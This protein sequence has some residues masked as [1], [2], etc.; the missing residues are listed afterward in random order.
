MKIDIESR[1]HNLHLRFPTRLLCSKMIVRIADRLGRKYAAE[2]MKSIPPEALEKLCAE[3]RRT[4]DR[5]GKWDLVDVEAADGE[6]VK[7]VL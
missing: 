7:I 4:K 6:K 1:E 2:Q 3:L 5:Y